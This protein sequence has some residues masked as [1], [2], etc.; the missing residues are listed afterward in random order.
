MLS[1]VLHSERAIQRNIAIM[2]ACVHLKQM[3]SSNK[4]LARRL[5]ELEK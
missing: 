3:I 4:T 1:S 5:N 2:R